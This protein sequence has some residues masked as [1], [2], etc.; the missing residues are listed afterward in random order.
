L[1]NVQAPSQA[2]RLNPFLGLTVHFINISF[3]LVPKMLSFIVANNYFTDDHITDA[4]EKNSS[5]DAVHDKVK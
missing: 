1:T 4:I 3:E 2:K 5:F